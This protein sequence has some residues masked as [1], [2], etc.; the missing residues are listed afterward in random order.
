MREGLQ[1]S[2]ADVHEFGSRMSL[3]D[4]LCCFFR[5]PSL[6]G[7]LILFYDIYIFDP[8]ACRDLNSPTRD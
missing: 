8:V 5:S 2:F 6:S 4:L 1:A 7:S 3:H